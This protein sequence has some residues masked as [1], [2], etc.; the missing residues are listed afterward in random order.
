MSLQQP[1]PGELRSPP[2]P[3]GRGKGPAR[4]AGRVRGHCTILY[5]IA[6]QAA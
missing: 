6:E 5:G 4:G 1:S 2:S 3:K